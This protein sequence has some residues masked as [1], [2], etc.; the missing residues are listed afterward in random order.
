MGCEREPRGSYGRRALAGWPHTPTPDYREWRG[1]GGRT[2]TPP[3]HL[4]RIR[5]PSP[6]WS[7]GIR[8]RRL[9][10][11]Y[12]SYLRHHPRTGHSLRFL[13]LTFT[14]TGL[15]L[16]CV[17][18]VQRSPPRHLDA[19]RGSRCLWW[20]VNW[21]LRPGFGV[22]VGIHPKHA[23]VSLRSIGRDSFAWSAIP[24]YEPS[25]RWV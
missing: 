5:I 3:P 9:L 23:P 11:G 12:L 4:R 24:V 8:R 20:E 10:G 1:F 7:W 6:R 22:A 14:W 21:S 25:V 15:G 19:L 13:T 17:D 16:P 2:R 18:A